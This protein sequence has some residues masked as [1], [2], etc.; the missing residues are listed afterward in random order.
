MRHP[1]SAWVGTTE[2]TKEP[3]EFKHPENE[4]YVLV[5][6]P[7][8]NTPKFPQKDYLKKVRFDDYD[9]YIIISRD[10]LSFRRMISGWLIK[11]K[12]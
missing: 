2:T 4:N 6:L 11:R 12:V 1:D 9:C 7:G 3:K 8:V 5:D 10:L